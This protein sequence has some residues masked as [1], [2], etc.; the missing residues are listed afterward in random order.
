EPSSTLIGVVRPVPTN[1][2]RRLNWLTSLTAHTM[3]SESHLRSGKATINRCHGTHG[4]QGHERRHANDQTRDDDRNANSHY[5]RHDTCYCHANRGE[6]ERYHPINRRD[7]SK[8]LFRH[9]R[10]HE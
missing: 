2:N 10:L 7:S 9:L 4:G 1:R 5:S 3:S 8:D 6:A